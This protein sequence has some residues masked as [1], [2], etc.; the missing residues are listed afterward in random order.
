MSASSGTKRRRRRD[1]R[2]LE[3]YDTLSMQA[4]ILAVVATFGFLAFQVAR[5]L[6]SA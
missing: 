1:R 4:T 2:F 5:T 3:F 6:V